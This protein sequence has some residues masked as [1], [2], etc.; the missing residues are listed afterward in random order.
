MHVAHPDGGTVC[1]RTIKRH[2]D[3][4]G[5]AERLASLAERQKLTKAQRDRLTR[6]RQ[7]LAEPATW[8]VKAADCRN[9]LAYLRKRP[10]L[11][12]RIH[13]ERQLTI[14]GS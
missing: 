10:Q 14:P 6:A 12:N 2:D 4:A 11:A 5:D 1:Q 9:C 8:I 7:V 13:G 3:A